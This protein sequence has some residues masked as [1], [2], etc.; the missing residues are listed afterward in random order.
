M[1]L[2][3]VSS[4]LTFFT[5]LLNIVSA[6]HGTNETIG[7]RVGLIW[8]P[9]DRNT[10]TVLQSCVITLLSC[11]WAV[12]HLN[13]PAPRDSYWT[14]FRRKMKWMMVTLLAPE[15][16]CSVALRQ[17]HESR[18]AVK[19]MKELGIEWTTVQGFYA[20][21]GGYVLHHRGTTVPLLTS[22]IKALLQSNSDRKE[23]Q[24]QLPTVDE[25]DIEDRNKTSG[26]TKFFALAQ[27]SWVVLQCIIRKAENLPISQVE[28][29]TIA[30]AACAIVASAFW[31]HKPLDIGL[32]VP[33]HYDGDL[34]DSIHTSRK[35]GSW[36]DREKRQRVKMTTRIITRGSKKSMFFNLTLPLFLFSSIFSV[37]HLAAWNLDFAT[38]R[39]QLLWRTSSLAATLAPCVIGGSLQIASIW[40]KAIHDEAPHKIV[41]P[42][43]AALVILCYFISVA[44]YVA[45]RVILIFQ[46][47]YSLRSMP[48]QIYIS[49]PWLD[50]IPHV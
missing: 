35:D 14:Q 10:L 11:T 18:V 19:E 30:F 44:A 17:W 37:I 2:R 31:W 1:W 36:A 34:P 27:T 28:I 45:A 23:T 49:V 47:F 7:E 20:V 5:C 29:A 50:Y 38:R 13:I 24:F 46:V 8:G 15:I 12:L 33:V 25:V 3:L 41:A 21:M 32:T 16:T 6:Q 43:F 26:F 4:T 42:E 9:N 40:D 48:P 22:E 39:E